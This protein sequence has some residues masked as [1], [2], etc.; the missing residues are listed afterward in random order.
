MSA[1]SH[2]ADDNSGAFA[3]YVIAAIIVLGAVAG[4]LFM[5]LGGFIL[6]FVGLTF[7]MLAGMVVASIS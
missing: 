7:V 3:A 2:S 4:Y 6:W 5:G 1:A